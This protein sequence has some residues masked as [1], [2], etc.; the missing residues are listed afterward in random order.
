MGI[1]LADEMLHPQLV[2]HFEDIYSYL[3]VG[4]R[5]TE[6]QYHREVASGLDIPVGMKNPTSGDI[7]TMLNSIEAGQ[8]PS[9]YTLGSHV[10]D[11]TGN[12]LVHGILR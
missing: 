9:H 2:R 4:A 3:A 5:S 10:I 7:K 8:S 6:N 11:S 1:P 12:P